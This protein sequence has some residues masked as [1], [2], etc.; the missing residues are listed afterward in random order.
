M[1]SSSK[2]APPQWLR[3]YTKIGRALAILKSGTLLFGPVRKWEDKNDVRAM[4]LYREL[5]NVPFASAVCFTCGNET[6]HHWSFF[7][8]GMG[9][10]IEF[11]AEKL[12]AKINKDKSLK[13][14]FIRDL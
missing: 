3:H 1:S 9:C 4:E 12:L 13:P 8:K 5:K 11:N 10:R 2:P 14:G 6:V 7:G